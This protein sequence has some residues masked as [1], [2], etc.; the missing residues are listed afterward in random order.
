VGGG[1]GGRIGLDVTIF[2]CGIKLL[3]IPYIALD[4]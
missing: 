3:Y 2:F 4:I 1:G